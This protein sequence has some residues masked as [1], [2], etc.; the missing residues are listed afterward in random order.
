MGKSRKSSPGIYFGPLASSPDG[1]NYATNVKQS[2]EYMK[3]YK[4]GLAINKKE[5]A[6]HGVEAQE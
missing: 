6:D 3:K 4:T 2:P 1:K 5:H